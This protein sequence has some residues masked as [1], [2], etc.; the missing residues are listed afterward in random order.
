MIQIL[1]NLLKYI[2]F[3]QVAIRVELFH[4]DNN[5]L[6][7]QTLIKWKYSR[8]LFITK[9]LFVLFLETWGPQLEQCLCGF[10]TLL[11][12]VRHDWPTKYDLCQKCIKESWVWIS[13]INC[14][15]A[16]VTWMQKAR[17]F[18]WLSDLHCLSR[19]GDGQNQ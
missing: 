15:F 12:W 5:K 8:C 16:A 4:T 18:V 3:P 9:N 14:G 17:G 13:S 10:K 19:S 1:K 11:I 6:N 2:L 7:I